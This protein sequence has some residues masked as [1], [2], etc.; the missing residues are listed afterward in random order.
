MSAKSNSAS[1]SASKISLSVIRVRARRRPRKHNQAIKRVD[2][3]VHRR[4]C[5]YRPQMKSPHRSHHVGWAWLQGWKLC[6]SPLSSVNWGSWVLLRTRM[7]PTRLSRSG[8]FPGLILRALAL[9]RRGG[10]KG[11]RVTSIGSLSDLRS[12]S[13]INSPRDIAPVTSLFP[14]LSLTSRGEKKHVVRQQGQN[15]LSIVRCCRW[16]LILLEVCSKFQ[17]YYLNK[18]WR[19]SDINCVLD[20]DSSVLTLK[21]TRYPKHNTVECWP[22]QSHES[23]KIH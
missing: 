15:I 3:L 18:I 13:S 22:H 17:M 10:E 19:F 1:K 14:R 2:S 8:T 7:M 21:S 11:A 20:H 6:P 5:L 12:R 9:S 4:L 16:G 23:L